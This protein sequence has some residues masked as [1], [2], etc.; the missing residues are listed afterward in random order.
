MHSWLWQYYSSSISSLSILHNM[1]KIVLLVEIQIM[2]VGM[3]QGVRFDGRFLFLL[4]SFIISFSLPSLCSS[5]GMQGKGLE[6]V[7]CRQEQLHGNRT[8]WCRSKS[9]HNYVECGT[10]LPN[11]HA[12]EFPHQEGFWAVSGRFCGHDRCF[13]A[14]FKIEA[15]IWV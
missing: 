2:S 8:N 6:R 13:K 10:R 9:I 11:T 14:V 4:F 7:F 3:F 12:P 1:Q 5:L 15:L